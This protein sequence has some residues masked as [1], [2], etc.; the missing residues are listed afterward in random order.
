MNKTIATALCAATFLM[1]TGCTSIVT[2]MAPD[3][4][5]E[6]TANKA[7][8]E[9]QN[10]LPDHSFA[11]NLCRYT[12][13]EKGDYICTKDAEI[14]KAEYEKMFGA[15]ATGRVDGGYAASI[16]LYA[17]S[18]A[19]QPGFFHSFSGFG[20]GALFL[21][22]G[23]LTGG[24]GRAGDN[25]FVAFV[26]YSKA[27]TKEEAIDYVFDSFAKAYRSTYKKFGFK[28]S[29]VDKNYQWFKL[30]NAVEHYKTITVY[31]D[32]GC[33]RYKDENGKNKV[34]CFFATNYF[35]HYLDGRLTTIPSWMPNAGEKAWVI[36]GDASFKTA[37]NYSGTLTQ[38]DLA[39][40][41][42][43]ALPDNFYLLVP[44]EIKGTKELPPFVVS[45][46]NIFFYAVPKN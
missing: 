36:S 28:E 24:P 21:I 4:M 37:K 29:A 34:K 25:R 46:K 22:G 3:P 30:G 40:D 6:E 14:P 32:H 2:A 43:K 9:Y 27:K 33:D 35:N 5:T 45:N 26:P 38:R 12:V 42:A 17:L 31:G 19:I 39:V 44:E 11:Y 41:E 1:T 7:L 10:Y 23:L 15:N 18:G 16:G 20:P 8:E 13:N